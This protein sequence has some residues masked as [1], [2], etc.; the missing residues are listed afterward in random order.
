[1]WW[2]DWTIDLTQSPHID[3]SFWPWF[4]FNFL[5][6]KKCCS[7]WGLTLVV[8]NVALVGRRSQVLGIYYPPACLAST[9]IHTALTCITIYTPTAASRDTH[10]TLYYIYTA[11]A[12]TAL[13]GKEPR[14]AQHLTRRVGFKIPNFKIPKV[15]NTKIWYFSK[16]QKGAFKIPKGA[17]KIPTSTVIW[18]PQFRTHYIELDQNYRITKRFPGWFVVLIK[19]RIQVYIDICLMF[20]FTTQ[21]KSSKALEDFRDCHTYWAIFNRIGFFLNR[22]RIRP[23]WQRRR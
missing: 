10:I 19:T 5:A 1:M 7:I 11:K 6:K 8:A 18:Q 3:I 4:K 21:A 9:Y 13:D 20:F 16:Y 2:T 17:F 12:T 23:I 15:H 22:P 14:K